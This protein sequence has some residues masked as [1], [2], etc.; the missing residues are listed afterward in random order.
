MME[1]E[2]HVVLSC[3]LSFG[4]PLVIAIRELMVLRRDGRAGGGLGR[5]DD[6]Q[7][8]PPTPKPRPQ[9]QDLAARKPLPDCLVPKP[10][11]RAAPAAR[12]LELV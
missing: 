6:P 11:R 5:R 4:V 3:A 8:K 10:I 2:M 9:G 12:E 7:P 1:P